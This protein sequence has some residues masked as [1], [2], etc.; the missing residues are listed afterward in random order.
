MDLTQTHCSTC[1]YRESVRCISSGYD[2]IDYTLLT[3][4]V[5]WLRQETHTFQL[6]VGEATIIMQ[7][8]AILLGLLI[9]R[10]TVVSPCNEWWTSH[11]S[12]IVGFNS[13]WSSTYW[14]SLR[15]TW[16]RD[17]FGHGPTND[18]SENV[19]HQFARAYILA[20]LGNVLIP[21]KPGNEVR[22]FFPTLLC[23]FKEAGSYGVAWP[24]VAYITCC[25]GQRHQKVTK[26]LV[27]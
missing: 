19:V 7:D 18:V 6:P 15:G 25:A 11:L 5:E 27:S 20:L 13:W 22:L 21:D 3:L 17:N 4:L 9:D 23:N 2:V 26:S 12:E 14:I 24:S 8:I 16:L 1:H 10:R